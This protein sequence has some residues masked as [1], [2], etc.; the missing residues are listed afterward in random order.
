[1]VTVKL[2]GRVLPPHIIMSA[3]APELRWKWDEEKL[4]PKFRVKIENSLVTVE[5]D[6]D[7]YEPR[8]ISEIYKRGSDLAR[9]TANMVAFDTGYGLVVMLDTFID[10][11]GVALPAHR[12]EMIPVSFRTAFSLDPARHAEFEQ[13]FRIVLSEPSVFIALDDLIKAITSTHTQLADCG[14]VIDRIRRM[15]APTLDGGPAWREMHQALNIAQPY[16]AWVSKQSTGSRHGDVAFVPPAVCTVAIQR[17][18]A[19]LNRFLEYR[20]RGN[21]PLTAPDFPQLV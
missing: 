8:F 11:S 15:I 2:T 10:P 4:E 6:I 1:M 7:R 17:T 19:I 18:W 9:A 20:K 13:A 5:C 14:R 3:Q 21:K 12:Q 16:Q